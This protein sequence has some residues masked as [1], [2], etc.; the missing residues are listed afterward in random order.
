MFVFQTLVSASL[1]CNTGVCVC[2][3]EEKQEK[4]PLKIIIWKHCS[5]H[6]VDYPAEEKCPLCNKQERGDVLVKR[7]KSK[8]NKT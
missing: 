3:N 5:I 2:M 6:N 1:I 4:T 7:E 8:N